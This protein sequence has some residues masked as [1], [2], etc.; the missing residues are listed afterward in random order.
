MRGKAE[1]L[2]TL[3]F[4]LNY[5]P[6]RGANSLSVRVYLPRGEMTN[7]IMLL[8]TLA[9]MGVLTNFTYVWLDYS[10]IQAQTFSNKEYTERVGWHYDNRVYMA[11][12][13]GMLQNMAKVRGEGAVFQPMSPITAQ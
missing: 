6:L 7:L 12:L 1:I 13:D 10:T 2:S 11:K 9:R 5:T 3:P 8:S 4:V